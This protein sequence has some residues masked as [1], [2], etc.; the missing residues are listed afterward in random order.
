MHVCVVESSINQT[1]NPDLNAWYFVLFIPSDFFEGRTFS[2]L[3]YS[4]ATE[5][6]YIMMGEG[7]SVQ[8]RRQ[9]LKSNVLGFIKY[10]FIVKIEI[11]RKK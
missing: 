5:E 11:N 10:F 2:E 3:V 4:K 6:N 1:L 7:I 9:G 8:G